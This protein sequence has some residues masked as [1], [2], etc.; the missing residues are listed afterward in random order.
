MQYDVAIIGGGPGGATTGALIKKYNP[1][2]RVGIFEREVFPRDHIGESLLPPISLILEE[3]GCWH[4]V[5]RAGFPVKLGATYTW[6]KTVDP[7]IFGFLP[8]SQIPADRTRPGELEGWRRITAFQVD[9]SV[10]DL[11]LLE[12]ARKLG[13]EV[14]QP[15]KVSQIHREGDRVS[16]LELDSGERITARYY[17][18]ASGNAAILRKAMGVTVDVPTLLKN[19]AFWDY[20]ENPDWAGDEDAEFTRINIRS[21]PFGWLWFIR[22]F[23]TRASVGLVCNAEYYKNCGKRPQE[24]FNEAIASESFVSRK[25]AGATCRGQVEATNDWSYVVDRTYGENWFLVGEVAGFAD[26]ILSAGVTLTQSGARELA[27][28]ILE[29]ERGELERPWLLDRY[30]ELQKRRVRQHMRFAEFWYSANGIFDAIRENCTQIAKDSGLRLNATDA[31]RWLSF[32]GLDDD[33]PGQVGVGGLDLAGVRQVMTRFTGSKSDWIIN[34]KNTFKLNLTNATESTVGRLENGRIRPVPCWN[35]GESRLI[36]IGLQGVLINALRA[37]QDIEEILRY[38]SGNQ[39]L[40]K[41][42][43]VEQADTRAVVQLLEVMARD[44]WVLASTKKNRPA[45]NVATPEEGAVM[46]TDT[47]GRF[48]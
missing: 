14:H 35:R 16:G 11:I 20:Y 37:S 30:D 48:K 28:T 8:E 38:V 13:C 10:Y 6:G 22:I 43:F 3:M 17:I 12:Q 44:Y 31:F 2:L 18:D 25:V 39:R 33:I 26:P 36:E 5:E 4:D 1:E 15:V 45:L 27:Y 34:G 24:L 19:V 41:G 7:W 32:G 42:G 46:H 29:L 47:T 21:L 9:R 23:P 40:L